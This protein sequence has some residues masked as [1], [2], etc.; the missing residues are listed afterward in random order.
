MINIQYNET[1]DGFWYLEI[2]EG[3]VYHDY[4][5]WKISIG[6]TFFDGFSELRYRHFIERLIYDYP[7]DSIE[8]NDNNSAAGGSK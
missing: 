4:L 8:D 6:W 7:E 2:Y 1:E 3:Y 5:G